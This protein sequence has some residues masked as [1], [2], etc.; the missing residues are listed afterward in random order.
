MQIT[1]Q[2]VPEPVRLTEGKF[3]ILFNGLFHDS[4][5]IHPHDIESQPIHKEDTVS[6][7]GSRDHPYGGTI[8]GVNIDRQVLKNF[9]G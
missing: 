8:S 9:L 6:L 1:I 2:N 7:C 5:K 4:M 3:N